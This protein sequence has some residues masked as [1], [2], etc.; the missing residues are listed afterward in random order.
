MGDHIGLYYPHFTFPNDAWIKL[1]ALYWDKL[2]RILPP[3]YTIHDSDTVQRLQGELGFTKDFTPSGND[4]YELGRMFIELLDT[5]RYELLASYGTHSGLLGHVLPRRD[6]L[7]YVY[8]DIKMSRQLVALLRQYG[9]AVDV[10]D[11][12]DTRSYGYKIIGMHPKLAAVYMEALA[13]QM[14]AS[15]KLHP[16]TNSMRDHVA[17]GDYTLERLAQALLYEDIPPFLDKIDTPMESEIARQMA[18]IAL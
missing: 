16:V 12:P 11:H 5:Y 8:S 18:A 13:G 15:K 14:A 3:D 4:T 10:R 6:G 9:L 7:S 1:A 2:G 17:M